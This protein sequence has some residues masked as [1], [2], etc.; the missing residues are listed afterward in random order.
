MN[1]CKIYIRIIDSRIEGDTM[2]M[3]RDVA[4]LT[5]GGC[6]VLAY[7]KYQE[8]VKKQMEKMMK[9]TDKALEDMI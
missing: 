6:A 3:V 9:K 1:V 5:V 4:M 7:Q 8:P 2:K